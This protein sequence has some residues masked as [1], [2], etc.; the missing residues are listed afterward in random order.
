[1]TTRV[2]VLT[3]HTSPTDQPGS[4]DSGGMNV[5]IVSL[6]S[7]LARRGV[8][9]DLFTRCRGGVDHEV[10]VI[11]PGARVVPIKAGP[12]APVPKADVPRFLPEFLGGVLRQA[13]EDGR[14][15]DLVHSHYW[16]SGWVGR[17]TKELWDV[18]L[19][20]S[21]HTLGKVK[22]YSLARGERPEPQVRLVAETR[23]IA[24]A[25]RI[26]APTPSEAGHLVG[27][28]GADPDRIRVV[29]QG[30]DHAI[31][32]PRSREE[33]R[34]RLH[35]AGLR[36]ALYVGRFQ[37]HKGPDV[38]VR[39]IAEAIAR[40]PG[41]T[42]H[43]MLALVG[44]PSGDDHGAEIARLMELAG[45]LGVAER[46]VLFP[47]Q[48]QPHLADFYA[49]ADVLL[50]PSRSE[51]FGLV[52]LEAQACGT[53]VV[54]ASVGGLPFV[55]EEGRTGLLVEGHDPADHADAML[56]ILRDEAFQDALGLEA[57]RR[58]LR[59]TWDTSAREMLA[60]YRE[61]VA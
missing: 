18:P 11:A 57:A 39:A 40:D 37:R 1:V 17:A 55:V 36:L 27:L 30:V 38:A 49:A 3:V 45:A 2:G 22:N 43:L 46:V 13:K 61:L 14:S 47:P 26:V 21:F 42:E 60:V 29:P 58:A 5:S 51:S 35:L 52:A 54:A 9:V 15:Y 20:T 25:D 4:G 19:V 56:R 48:P 33:A 44:G 53:P 6:A 41:T 32:T 50:V 8:E 34:A 28:Y 16:L 59:F 23:T 24:D 10:K 12:C 7:R 31:F